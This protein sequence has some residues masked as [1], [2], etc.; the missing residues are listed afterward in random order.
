MNCDSLNLKEFINYLGSDSP[1]PGGGGASAICGAIGMALG[2]MVGS[3]TLGKK[4]YADVEEDMLRMTAKAHVIQDRLIDLVHEDARAFLPLS[5]A[6][7]LPTATEEQK[8]EKAETM[9]KCLE[10]AARPP[11]EIMETCC[12]AIDL[13]AE[14]AEKGNRLVISDAGTGAAL[15]GAALRGASLNVFVNTGLMKDRQ[16]AAEIDDRASEMLEVY[17]GRADE[18]FADI[19]SRI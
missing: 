3:F 2:N 13:L 6:Y 8:K 14:F 4:K 5:M 10:E 19:R 15:C 12:S 11:L 16:K 17:V 18:I 7:G 9:E 1:T